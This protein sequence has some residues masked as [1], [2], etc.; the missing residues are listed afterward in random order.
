M[1]YFPQLAS[2]AL[3]Q[4][5]LRWTD[6]FRAATNTMPDGSTISL[7]D[8]GATAVSWH[9]AFTGLSE[10]ERAALQSFFETTQGARTSF[11]MLDPADNLVAYSEDFT[12]SCWAPGP[13]LQITPGISDPWGGTAAT[14]LT[15]T[16]QAVQA[17]T[18]QIDGA[19]GYR[20][21]F[22][23]YLRSDTAQTVSLTL[24]C[25][26]SAVRQAVVTSANWQR[27]VLSGVPGN[28]EGVS[29]GIEVA[30]GACV[31]LFGAQA[32]AQPAPGTY[33]KTGIRN[34]VYEDCRFDQDELQMIATGTGA[35]RCSLR[36]RSAVN[37]SWQA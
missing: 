1:L 14:A 19:G 6:N 10:G 12:Q 3:T 20:Y 30:S 17:L 2:G 22:S 35:Y 33:K 16:A 15:N 32:E 24:S 34:G 21:C 31:Q 13:L 9:F 8:N 5:P 28:G 26:G 7:A 18:Q 11:T 23:V 25:A 27:A 29:F 36:V 4:F 37:I